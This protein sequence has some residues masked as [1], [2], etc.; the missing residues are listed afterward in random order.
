MIYMKECL[1]MFSSRSFMVSSLTFRSSVHFVYLCVGV[2]ECSDFILLY[3]SVQFSQHHLLKRL[4]SPH[5][6]FLL[7]LS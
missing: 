4:P 6:L 5:C 1:S 3:V 2:R 7:P